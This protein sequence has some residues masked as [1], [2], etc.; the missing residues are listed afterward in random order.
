MITSNVMENL[1][2]L[3]V[4]VLGGEPELYTKNCIDH[5][6]SLSGPINHVLFYHS[7]TKTK[8]SQP[9]KP[10][11][12]KNKNSTAVKNIT[13]PSTNNCSHRSKSY[14]NEVGCYI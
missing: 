3:R 7:P 5:K 9:N 12:K 11:A 2:V 6:N 10:L 14:Q 1:Y 4:E 8:N 13:I